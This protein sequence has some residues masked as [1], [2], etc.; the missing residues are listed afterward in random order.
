MNKKI[1]IIGL[2]KMGLNIA[3]NLKDKNIDVF[4]FT[5]TKEGFDYAK[6]QGL[7]VFSTLDETISNFG[8]DTRIFWLMV[9]SQAVDTV[10][11]SESEG[12]AVKLKKG[13]IIIDG[14]NSHYKDSVERYNKLKDKGIHFIDCGTSG[15]IEG[16]RHGACLMV[17]GDKEIYSQIEWVFQSVGSD[18]SYGY[19]GEAGSGHY[20]KMIHNSIE[21]GMLQAIAEGLN[22]VE[23]GKYSGVNIE[24]LLGVWNHGSIVESY[25]TKVL[26][27]QLKIYP[28]LDEIAPVVDDNGEGAWTVLEAIEQRIPLSVGSISLFERYNSKGENDDANKFIAL[29]RNGFGGHAITRQN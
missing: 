28:N 23:N 15:G 21:Y 1:A 4:G 18:K 6:E 3:L 8:E 25:L 14:G 19:I 2:G 5:D 24:S 29:M 7:N 20:V 12:I 11:F 9:P 13:D 16:A 26:E 22:L 10:L 17:G 27:K